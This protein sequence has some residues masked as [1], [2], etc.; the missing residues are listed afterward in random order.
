MTLQVGDSFSCEYEV[1][2]EHSAKHMTSGGLEVLATPMLIC[3]VENACMEFIGKELD[4][5]HGTVGASVSLH[6]NAPTSIGDK[7]T[8]KGKLVNIH[9]DKVFSFEVECFDS[10]GK[11]ADGSHT[12][13]I[14]DSRRFMERLAAR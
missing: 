14:V 5:A 12:R 3:Y 8:V 2:R 1:K 11:V 10:K 13:V 4:E 6:H 7:I 9:N